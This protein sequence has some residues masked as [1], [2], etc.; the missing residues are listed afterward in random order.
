[1]RHPFL[2][3]RKNSVIKDHDPRNAPFSPL[4]SLWNRKIPICLLMW[5][6]M[7]DKAGATR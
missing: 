1:M 5:M 7:L 2:S 3:T 4:H 6:I